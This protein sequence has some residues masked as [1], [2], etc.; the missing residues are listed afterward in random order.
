MN[1]RKDT[2]K[3]ITDLLSMIRWLELQNSKL[4][5]EYGKMKICIFCINVGIVYVLV[6]K[7]AIFAI[8]DFR[9]MYQ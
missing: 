6:E 3:D 7:G 8:L 1:T 2:E 9:L 4:A 5:Q